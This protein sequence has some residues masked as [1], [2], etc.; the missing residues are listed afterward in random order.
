M[1]SASQSG[2][3]QPGVYGKQL[4]ARSGGNNKVT[5]FPQD[6]TKQPVAEKLEQCAPCNSNYQF[7]DCGEK[8]GIYCTD[9]IATKVYNELNGRT[10]VPNLPFTEK[11]KKITSLDNSPPTETDNVKTLQSRKH[12]NT[13]RWEELENNICLFRDNLLEYSKDSLNSNNLSRLSGWIAQV[14]M[15]VCEGHISPQEGMS[16]CLDFIRNCMDQIEDA[17]AADHKNQ[18]HIT[19]YHNK[20]RHEMDTYESCIIRSQCYGI[21]NKNHGMVGNIA[22][23][24]GLK[25]ISNSDMSI[26]TQDSDNNS[27]TET[28]SGTSIVS[29][30]EVETKNTENYSSSHSSRVYNEHKAF[31]KKM[32]CYQLGITLLPQRLK[33]QI[34]LCISRNMEDIEHRGYTANDALEDMQDKWGPLRSNHEIRRLYARTTY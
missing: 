5:L 26:S 18:I 33:A 29:T 9:K 17:A 27:T 19:T 8:V 23:V 32:K 4:L 6:N 30:S 1:L 20:L 13:V 10:S 7:R 11:E 3:S 25:T 15:H 16:R 28:E 24:D 31:L 14:K 2:W 34:R 21:S 12:S 22:F